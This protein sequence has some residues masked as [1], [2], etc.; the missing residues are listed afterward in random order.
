MIDNIF[1]LIW[2]THGTQV[3]KEYKKNSSGYFLVHF[4]SPLQNLPIWI[5]LTFSIISKSTSF[6]LKLDL[7]CKLPNFMSQTPVPPQ[8]RNLENY[9]DSVQHRYLVNTYVIYTETDLSIVFKVL[10]RLTFTLHMTCLTNTETLT[11]PS[12]CS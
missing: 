10:M 4:I 12:S 6:L 11:L 3:M 1:L 9:I 5:F 2:G 8:D 7:H